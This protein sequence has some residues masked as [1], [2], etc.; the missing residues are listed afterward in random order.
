MGAQPQVARRRPQGGGRKAARVIRRA[1][2]RA[3]KRR[4]RARPRM[5]PRGQQGGICCRIRRIRRIRRGRFCRQVDCRAAGR[6]VPHMRQRAAGCGRAGRRA[7]GPPARPLPGRGGRNGAGAGAA[8][9]AL[10]RA[11][12][13]PPISSNLRV[14]ACTGCPMGVCTPV[15]PTVGHLAGPPLVHCAI[16]PPPPQEAR[17]HAARGTGTAVA[18]RGARRGQR[19]GS[20][21]P[22]R[23]LPSPPPVLTATYS[24]PPPPSPVA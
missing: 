14:V 16:P 15:S 23:S 18:G 3:R 6:Q 11:P 21:D 20:G 4:R 17:R 10:A 5:R 13:P 12:L 2:A 22:C 9:P 8:A 7:Y 1:G 24:L 19:T